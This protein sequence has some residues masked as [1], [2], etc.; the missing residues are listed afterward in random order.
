ML[1]FS[2]KTQQFSDSKGGE[3]VGKVKVDQDQ[4][5]REAPAPVRKLCS[6]AASSSSSC[7]EALP[8]PR[9][10]LCTRYRLAT[11]NPH[12]L[13]YGPLSHILSCLPGLGYFP[14]L[15]TLTIDAL[16]CTFSSHFCNLRS[17]QDSQVI[18]IC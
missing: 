8:L 3:S 6:Q 2:V 15:Y 4:R 12:P 9:E 16:L 11:P 17:L 1:V 14:L 5:G 18:K 13:P 10:A 7:N